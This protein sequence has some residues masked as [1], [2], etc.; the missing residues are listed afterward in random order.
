VPLIELIAALWVLAGPHLAVA[1][2]GEPVRFTDLYGASREAPAA[3]ECREGRPIL[4]LAPGVDAPTLAHE[5]AHAYDCADDGRMNAS[6]IGGAR[7]PERPEW[8]STYCWNTDAEWYACWAVHTGLV[9]TPATETPPGRLARAASM[10]RRP[11]TLAL[12]VFAR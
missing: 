11:L 6:P 4:H 8:A 5:L 7:P 10:L 12:S 2:L 9:A 1:P 3:L